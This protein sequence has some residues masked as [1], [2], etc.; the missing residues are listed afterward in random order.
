[1]KSLVS[2]LVAAV[3]LLSPV[4][5]SA[6]G[7]A[8]Q[9]NQVTS[10]NVGIV[11]FWTLLSA[12]GLNITYSGTTA[13]CTATVTGV[14]SVNSITANFTLSRVNA[15]GSLTSVRTWFNQSSSTNQLS[16]SGTYSPVSSGQTYQLDMVATL[17]TS[18]GASETVSRSVRVTY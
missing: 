9:N 13:T 11:P 5:A 7:Y 15:N 2:M 16:F 12:A 6:S 18:G 10:A 1:M 3:L 14:S 8:A 17:K 4:S